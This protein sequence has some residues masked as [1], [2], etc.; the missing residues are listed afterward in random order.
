[1]KVLTV[2]GARPQFI[3]AAVVS[4]AFAEHG[5]SITEVLVHTGQHYDANMSDIFF[6]ELEIPRPDY[7]LAI[8]GGTHGQNTGRMIEKLEE[9]MIQEKPDWVLVYGDT[10]STLAGAL[11][12]VKL[13]IP[14]AH[15]E[16]GLRSFNRKMPEEINRVMT[17]HIST[18]LFAPTGVALKHLEKEGVGSEKIHVVG[19]VMCDATHYY[20]S[21]A[22]KPAWFDGLGLQTNQFALCTIHRAENTDSP[23]RMKDIFKGLQLAELPIILPL[24]PRT[25]SKLKQSMLAIPGNVHVVD[26]LGYLEMNWLEA[27]CKL[28]CTDSG[29]VQKE[30]YFHGKACVTL[31]DETEWVE[32]VDRGVNVIVGASPELIAGAMKLN[33]KLNFDDP[34]YGDGRSAAK[35]VDLLLNR[36]SV[37]S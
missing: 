12:A 2:I 26:P 3:K 23:T 33:Q 18:M 6:E 36:S 7:N 11:A 34:L 24:H 31:R 9:L 13:H 4:R 27:N 16:A 35:I 21:R 37:N 19:D 14:I 10:D 22:Q 30:A 15:V 20:K 29:G 5:S 1:M 28:I 8:G 25:R 32:L 17:D